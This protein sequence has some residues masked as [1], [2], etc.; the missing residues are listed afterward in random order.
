M[1]GPFRVTKV[2]Q[3]AVVLPQTTVGHRD[4]QPNNPPSIATNRTDNQSVP[5]DVIL[6]FQPMFKKKKKKKKIGK[7]RKEEKENFSNPFFTS[8]N[9]GRSSGFPAQNTPHKREKTGGKTGGTG[10]RNPCFPNYF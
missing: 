7:K 4:S 6:V 9:R 10:G 1:Q 2:S 5:E 3:A 8:S